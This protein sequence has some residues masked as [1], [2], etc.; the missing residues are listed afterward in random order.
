M[1]EIMSETEGKVLVVKATEKL[2]YG[3][4]E[5]VFIPKLNQMIEEYGKIRVVMYLA[6]DFIGWEVEAAWDD[7]KFG[8]E[9]RN[10]FEKIAVVGGPKWVEWVTRLSA[11][12][13]AGHVKPYEIG[14]LQA[15]IS[16]VKE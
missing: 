15:A 16:W 13:I 8:L 12:F 2:T 4:Y 5:E 7:A 14:D 10:D 11:Y 6:E 3:D 9:H 1:I